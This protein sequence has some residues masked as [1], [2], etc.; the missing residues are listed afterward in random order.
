MEFKYYC[1]FPLREIVEDCRR[2]LDWLRTYKMAEATN[3]LSAF[4]HLAESLL[5]EGDGRDFGAAV[6]RE[7]GTVPFGTSRSY[8]ILAIQWFY[9][10]GRY[11]E[12]LHLAGVIARNIESIA[13]EPAY[14]EYCF[15]YALCISASWP[16]MTVRER[17]CYRKLFKKYRS[18]FRKWA[19]LG[20]ENFEHRRLLLE[21]EA[22]RLRG[23]T[24]RT[25]QFYEEAIRAAGENG[26]PP[27]TGPGQ[28]A[29]GGILP[30]PQY[31][32]HCRLL[33]GKKPA[34]VLPAGEPGPWSAGFRNS[35]PA[36]KRLFPGIILNRRL[37]H[38]R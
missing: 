36:T 20:P 6:S 15:Y 27:R 24:V 29:G 10:M 16:G 21:A 33:P 25:M 9:L 26:Y 7:A 1:G 8:Y 12:G 2:H 28:S 23:R 11:R 37:N 17:R 5:E 19:R 38:G 4:K 34:G 32:R 3:F 18:C 14:P 35:I 31:G 13:R 22:A 30:G